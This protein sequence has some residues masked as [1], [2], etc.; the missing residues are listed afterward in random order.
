MIRKATKLY[1]SEAAMSWVDS[2]NQLFYAYNRMMNASSNCNGHSEITVASYQY[3]AAIF[4]ATQITVTGL[5]E[6]LGVK[7]ASVTQMIDSLS[8]KG[9]IK[10]TINDGDKR[11]YVIELAEK[12]KRLMESDN[13]IHKQFEER[14]T[15]S[16]DPHELKQLEKLLAKLT[17]EVQKHA[18]K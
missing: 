6:V 8:H 11:S 2:F 13:N 18:I 17:A 12:G 16:L 9:Y 3:L 1:I 14:I 4:D 10:K 5:S 7:K 15:K